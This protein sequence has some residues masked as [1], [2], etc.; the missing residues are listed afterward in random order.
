[1]TTDIGLLSVEEAAQQ[2]AG[3]WRDFRNFAWS[4]R[5]AFV[6]AEQWGIA[7]THHRDSGLRA[8]S[9]AAAIEK[10]LSRF[11]DDDD[12]DVLEEHHRH[13]AYGW[14]DGYAIRV[15]RDGKI[16][17]AFKVYHELT[18]RLAEYP[19]L[20]EQDYSRREYEA[21]LANIKDLAWRLKHDYELPD[22]WEAQVFDWLWQHRQ[23][24]LENHDDQGG[25][26]PEA[27][28]EAAFVMLGYAPSEQS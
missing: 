17:E 20:D 10:E 19:V 18:E 13:W 12:P 22:G 21:T 3:N 4:R 1:M 5:N 2:M 7:Y 8:L 26:P 9:N 24:A 11:L 14:V 16:T 28:L 15:Y 27:D 6:D 23:H 25:Y